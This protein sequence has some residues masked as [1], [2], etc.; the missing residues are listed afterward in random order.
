[1]YLP[2]KIGEIYVKSLQ[3]ALQE[4]ILKDFLLL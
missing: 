1:M 2:K 4:K 3:K